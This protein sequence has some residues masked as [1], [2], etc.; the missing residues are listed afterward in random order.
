MFS[1]RNVVNRR[2]VKAD[3]S[4]AV[5]ACRRLFK[6]E[7]EARVIAAVMHILDLKTLD[8]KPCEA[9]MPPENTQQRKTWLNNIATKV[10]DM[11]IVDKT[12]NEAI[13]KSSETLEQASKVDAF[14][15]YPCRFPGCPKSFAKN[16]KWRRAHEMKH[17]PPV[18]IDTS[19]GCD[20]GDHDDMLAYQKSLLDY[21]MLL[22]NFFDAISESDG[23]RVVRS[24]KFFLMYM[25]HQEG[26][27][28]YALEALYVMFQVYGLLSPQESHKFKWN[29]FIKN[30]SGL[31]GHIPLDLQLEFYNRTVKEAIKNLGPNAAV[32]S[33]NRICH[34]LHTTTNLMDVFDADYNVFKR[35]GKHTKKSQDGDLH[36]IVQQLV[37]QQAFKF[38]PGRSYRFYTDMSPNLLM[39]FD[40]KK[41]YE[42]VN[43][44]KKYM[45][46]RRRAR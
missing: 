13:Q 3:V 32:K 20:D 22:L 44:H 33:I 15:R 35:S 45:I 8:D 2:N 27:S 23:D 30:K 28:K 36:K 40:M 46:V 25:K 5:N 26:S 42:W 9:S 31:G 24:W 19:E 7:V 34:S 4:S 17:E 38:T 14:G 10:V 41:F 1:D 16:G 11:F 6:L 29:R 18:I 39:N 43:L 12:R 21:G 37:T